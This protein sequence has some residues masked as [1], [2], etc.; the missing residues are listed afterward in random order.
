MFYLE[1]S[2]FAH[3]E[4]VQVACH[5][6][7]NQARKMRYLIT[8]NLPP[9]NN[10]LEF[11]KQL[12]GIKDLEID[13]DYGLILISP[14]RDLYVIRVSGDMDSQKLIAIQPLVKGVHGDIK[15]A[16][17]ESQEEEDK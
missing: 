5:L 1:Y 12:D 13:E 14:K 9:P 3:L 2:V 8:L 17:T 15:I 11:V 6:N 10:S 7:V 4:T 16:P